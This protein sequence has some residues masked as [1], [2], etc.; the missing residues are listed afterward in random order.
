MAKVTGIG[1]IFFKA[2]NPQ[3]ITDWYQKHLG[4]LVEETGVSFLWREKENPARIGRTV[5]SPF[6]ESTTYFDPSKS[7]FMLNFRVD[8]LDEIL[9]LLKAQGVHVIDKVEEYEYG[10]FDWILDPEGNKVELW[11]PLGEP[12]QKKI[13]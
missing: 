1:G 5:W 3:A 4:I 13:E 12:G 9:A 6:P 11:G 7:S 8:N 2:K 10:R